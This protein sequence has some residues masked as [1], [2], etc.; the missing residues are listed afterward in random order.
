MRSR[1]LLDFAHRGNHLAS[2]INNS[3][4]YLQA[5]RSSRR[6]CRNS[7]N[8]H[9]RVYHILLLVIQC[10]R[11]SGSRAQ[12]SEN[13]DRNNP[14]Y[15]YAGCH[16]EKS[17]P[18]GLFAEAVGAVTSFFFALHTHKPSYGQS[19]YRIYGF[20]VLF[21]EK[22]RRQANPKFLH[23]Y[24]EFFGGKKMPQLMQDD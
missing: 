8:S 6:I 2:N 16:H 17:L 20:P 18:E 22:A 5:R 4:A 21:S 9:M 12:K 23:F 19:V 15:H 7:N 3:I 1:K 14:K 24:S 11:N 13:D 10:S